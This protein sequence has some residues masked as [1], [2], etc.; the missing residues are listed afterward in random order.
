MVPR[1]GAVVVEVGTDFGATIGQVY[2]LLV[3]FGI[4]DGARKGQRLCRG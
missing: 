1:E 4:R 2:P 3:R